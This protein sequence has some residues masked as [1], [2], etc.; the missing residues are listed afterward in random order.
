MC[1]ITRLEDER[2][3]PRL[4]AF[5]EWFMIT[6]GTRMRNFS[7]L[8]HMAATVAFERARRQSGN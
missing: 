6:L 4:R 7:K 8:A 3:S 1:L 5:A 2:N